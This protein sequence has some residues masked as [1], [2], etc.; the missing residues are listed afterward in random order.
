MLLLLLGHS[1]LP[2]ALQKIKE[3]LRALLVEKLQNVSKHHLFDLL[4]WLR[5][6]HN[7]AF[8]QMSVELG[9]KLDP[10]K[11]AIFGFLGQKGL[12]PKVVLCYVCT[13]FLVLLLFFL[14]PPLSPFQEGCPLHCYAIYDTKN[15]LCY[16]WPLSCYDY[17]TMT[18]MVILDSLGIWVS[19]AIV[20]LVK[21]TL[22]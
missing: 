9:S 10:N 19:I 17:G 21:G 18:L 14:F 20:V 11:F 7:S 13:T 4:Y 8:D 3:G 22:I 6:K 5:D 16:E 12:G 1:C 2:V 15:P